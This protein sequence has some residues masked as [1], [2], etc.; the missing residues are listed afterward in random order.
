MIYI[1]SPYSSPIVGAQQLRFEKV[2]KF[3]V[4]LF[5]QGLVPFSPIVYAH[6]MAAAGGLRT[7]AQSWLKFNSSML[8]RSEAVFV[9]CLPGWRESEGV[10]IELGQAKAL[11][12]EVAYFDEDFNGIDTP[13]R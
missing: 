8:R 12:I 11:Q 10:T 7:D 2:R 1:A 4:Y 9:Y 5:N 13:E 6:E 3:S